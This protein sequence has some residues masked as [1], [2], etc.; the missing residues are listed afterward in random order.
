MCHFWPPCTLV[1]MHSLRVTLSLKFSDFRI[2]THFSAYFRCTSNM[3]ALFNGHQFNDLT[4]YYAFWYSSYFPS[5]QSWG[6]HCASVLL[7]WLRRH[8]YARASMSALGNLLNSRLEEAEIKR[9]Y[10]SSS[11]QN[12][13]VISDASTRTQPLRLKFGPEFATTH[14]VG[15][16]CSNYEEDGG[17]PPLRFWHNGFEGGLVSVSLLSF[18]SFCSKTAVPYFCA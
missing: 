3:A 4:F 13:A 18:Y 10:L 6:L 16:Q 11:S 8:I 14:C 2:L 5:A 9:N 1:D 7:I 17:Q 15:N 12:C